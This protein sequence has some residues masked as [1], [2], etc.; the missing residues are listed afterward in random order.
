MAQ[1][2]NVIIQP[3]PVDVKSQFL[4]SVTILTWNYLNKNYTWNA[5]S[6]MSWADLESQWKE[7]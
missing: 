1:L 2:E 6:G 4:L 7:K 5:V 3:N